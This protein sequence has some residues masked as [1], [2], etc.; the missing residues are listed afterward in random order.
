MPKP[1]VGIFL[2]QKCCSVEKKSHFDDL[3]FRDK[4]Y[5]FLDKDLRYAEAPPG[6]DS[7]V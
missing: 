1:G 2:Q 7:L 5:S 4:V 6:Q 3:H